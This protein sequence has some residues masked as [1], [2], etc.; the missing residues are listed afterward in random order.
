MAKANQKPLAEVV[1]IYANLTDEQVVNLPPEKFRAWFN[2]Q[3]EAYLPTLSDAD[4]ISVFHQVTE[5][6]ESASDRIKI[7]RA[8]IER[9]LI[10]NEKV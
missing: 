9:R 10:R 5:E 1:N 8:E 6:I 2:V 3:E 4:L 7:V